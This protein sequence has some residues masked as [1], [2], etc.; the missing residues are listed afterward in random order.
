VVTICGA[1]EEMLICEML[2]TKR[3]ALFERQHSDAIG[4]NGPPE[5]EIRD[6]AWAWSLAF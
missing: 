3:T 2:L 1:W 4:S 5:F 6:F